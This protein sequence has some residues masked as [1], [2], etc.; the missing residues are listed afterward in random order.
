MKINLDKAFL[1]AKNITQEE[2][3]LL[4]FLEMKGDFQRTLDSLVRKDF[5]TSDK[6]GNKYFVNVHGHDII[7]DSAI[8]EI[9]SNEYSELAQKLKDLYPKGKKS[10]PYPWTE[11]IQLI[12]KRLSLFEKK[13]GK[14]SDDDIYDATKRY[15]EAFNGN[16]TYMKT[17]KYFIC[18]EKNVNGSIES[19]SDLLTFI[20]NKGQEDSLSN[21]WSSILV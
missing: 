5:V 20:E 1:N 9:K 4:L 3:V 17:L 16:Y 7:A 18:A 6:V 11:G 13:Y 21:D 19:S 12:C 14:F 15:I 2:F 8:A 10:G